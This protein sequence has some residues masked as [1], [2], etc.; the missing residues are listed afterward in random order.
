MREQ[1]QSPTKKEVVDENRKVKSI[2]LLQGLHLTQTERWGIA[3]IISNRNSFEQNGVM[4][5]RSKRII[6]TIKPCE[7]SNV[8]EVLIAK[9]ESDGKGRTISRQQK[10]LVKVSNL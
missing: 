3:H 9:R 4:C 10:I 6:Y 8:F 5:A 2:S 7:D 1:P